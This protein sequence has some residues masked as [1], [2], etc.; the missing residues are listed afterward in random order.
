MKE[1]PQEL[2]EVLNGSCISTDNGTVMKMTG[3]LPP[4]PGL[5]VK[6][7]SS[8]RRSCSDF[9]T[10]NLVIS[11]LLFRTGLSKKNTMPSTTLLCKNKTNIEHVK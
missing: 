1:H 5:M 4:K 3:V 8:I 9:V 10:G 11:E 6:S 2:L 7:W